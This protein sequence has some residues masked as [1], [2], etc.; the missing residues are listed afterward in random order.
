MD[1]IL[2]ITNALIISIF[3]NILI[4]KNKNEKQT[5]KEK[6]KKRKKGRKTEIRRQIFVV[7]ILG[8]LRGHDH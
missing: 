1:W 8:T 3:I 6:K 5:C 7:I 4:F 2:C